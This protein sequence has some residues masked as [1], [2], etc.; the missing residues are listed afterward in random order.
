L[1]TS[2]AFP[3]NAQALERPDL[4]PKGTR[5]INMTQLAE[6]L[7]GE[8]PGPPVRALYV[9]NS[10]PAAIAPDQKRVLR[11]L[12]RD[13]LFTVVHEQFATDTVDYADIVLPATT[14]LEHFDLHTSYG[15]H[16]LQVN[17]ASIPPLAEARCN[18]DVF[19]QL[20]ARLGFEEK[21]FQVSD[22]Q[23][24]RQALW[25]GF[26]SV[27]AELR[28]ITLDRLIAE[29]PIRLNLPERFTP[30]AAGG[31]PTPSGKCE[32][33]CERLKAEGFDPLAT[34]I[35]PVESAEA[36]PALAARYP[37][38]LLSPPSPHFL[39]SSFVNV[40]SLRAAAEGPQLELHVDDAERRNIRSGDRVR[41]FN[42]RGEFE[43]TAVVGH[44]VR[45][46]VAVAPSVWWNKFTATRANVNAT[47]SSR[48]TDLG[49]GAT[50]F[51]NLVEVESAG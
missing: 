13:D 25:E 27:P 30:F 17:Q 39:N 37:L 15:H 32:F 38:Q 24:A 19:R 29:G 35:P 47:T 9:Y 10:N 14:Q 16:W 40:D 33:V 8:L 5:T 41:I 1:S 45:P 31:F 22:E 3:L 49:A 36:S 26:P 4:I 43:A 20:A 44:T 34:Y 2:A 46:G 12:E 7:N 18:T 11:G 48:L 42:D 28:G 21:L 51:D 23:L 50:F 6:A